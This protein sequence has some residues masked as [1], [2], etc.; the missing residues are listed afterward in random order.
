MAPDIEL[1]ISVGSAT[2]PDDATSVD[3]LVE[4]A[5]R[6]M[7]REKVARGRQRVRQSTVPARGATARSDDGT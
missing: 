3:D 4:H 5:D 2:Y 1:G 7:Y 6:A